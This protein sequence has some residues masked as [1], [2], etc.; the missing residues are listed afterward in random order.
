LKKL[1]NQLQ[2]YRDVLNIINEILLA[3]DKIRRNVRILDPALSYAEFQ[4]GDRVEGKSYCE[5]GNGDQISNWIV[6][7]GKLRFIYSLLIDVYANDH[8]LSIIIKHNMVT[9]YLEKMRQLIIPWSILIDSDE[10]NLTDVIDKDEIN[11]VL[12]VLCDNVINMANIHTHRDDYILAESH[13]QYA[14]SSA[15]RYDGEVE[16][17]TSL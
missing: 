10:I 8:S 12:R 3:P 4:F 2:P 1:S 15:K 13:C 14:L 5:R 7:R 9:P 11:I 17:K 16:E 6:E